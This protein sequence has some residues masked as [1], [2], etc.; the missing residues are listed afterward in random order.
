[1]PKEIRLGLFIALTL[2]ILFI[3]VFYIG[4]KEMLFKSTY[5][6][7]AQ[8]QNVGGLDVG[9]DVRVGG[10]HKGTVKGIDL[11]KQPNGKVTVVMDLQNATHDILRQDS[12]AAI[13]SEGLL[14]DKYVEVSFG[15]NGAEKLN[16]G[17]TIASAPPLD[18]SDLFAKANQLLDS[19][20]ETAS[21]LQSI[22]AKINS[23]KGSVG[24]FINDKTI[25]NQATK[26][27]T[28]LQ[29]DTEAVK[30]NFLVRGFFKNRGYEDA[31]ELTKH[32]IAKLPAG[33]AMKT[34][35]FDDAKIFDKPDNA[36]LKNQ[37]S[38]DEAGKFLE[39]NKFGLVAIA[40]YAGSKGDSDKQKKLT[41]ARAVAVRDFW[42]R[43]S[44]WM[45]PACGP[46]DSERAKKIAGA[47]KSSCTQPTP[48]PRRPGRP[49]QNRR[50][51]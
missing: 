11:P 47:L 9:A 26:A 31:E 19:S 4:D 45:T 40:S 20:A 48:L 3:G 6:L 12:Q 49:R 32:G 35:E 42:S 22:T 7:K 28:N 51:L 2:T 34:F 39:D 43:T 8:F 41:E 15:S 29:E 16:D 13:K 27:A 33:P 36:K 37:K 14:G 46:S 30:H 1:M 17:D 25:F 24:A 5:A 21:N 10:I 23:G 38:L 18:I 44:T 50:W